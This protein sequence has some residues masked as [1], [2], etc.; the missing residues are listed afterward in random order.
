MN[1]YERLVDECDK[2]NITVVE[3]KFK[4][5]AK[6][7]WKNNKIG[8]SSNIETIKEKYCTL[9]EE[10]GHYKKTY[11]N[12]LN[13]KD[14]KNKKQEIIAR[15]WGYNKICGLDKIYSALLNGARNR[16]E[17]AEMLNVTDEFFEKAI[18]YLKLKYGC[19]TYFKGI[20][21]IFEPNFGI[22]E[23]YSFKEG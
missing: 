23:K 7:L 8:I 17:I 11:G 6:G 1:S 15:R 21:F 10:Y 3:K 18:K 22:L 2:Q 16:Y 14:I 20:L 4:S 9:S 12:I 13:Q 5:N 19:S